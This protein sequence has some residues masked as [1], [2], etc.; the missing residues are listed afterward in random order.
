MVKPKKT[1][2]E[3]IQEGK[4][5]KIAR[6]FFLT[7]TIPSLVTKELYKNAWKIRNEKTQRSFVM[8]IVQNYLSEWKKKG[9]IETSKIKIPVKVERKRGKPYNLFSEGFLM[10]LEPIYSYCKKKGIKFNDEEKQF[11]K[12]NLLSEDIRKEILKEYPNEDI[13]NATIKYYIKNTIM[14]Y[15]FFL[16]DVRENPKKYKKQYKKAEE[17]NNPKTETGKKMKRF[18]KKIMKELQESY[19]SN[20]KKII[21]D[22]DVIKIIAYESPTTPSKILFRTYLDEIME[23]KEFIQKLDNKMLLALQISPN[24]KIKNEKNTPIKLVK[25]V[26]RPIRNTYGK[27]RLRINIMNF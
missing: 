13:I 6:A 21:L 23:N 24:L 4:G 17:L 15:F 9:F 20:T 7:F 16:K 18:H 19:G 25:K 12:L 11:L 1:E 22:F 26:G 5:K 14:K 2:L 10:N 27:E 8:P 3:R